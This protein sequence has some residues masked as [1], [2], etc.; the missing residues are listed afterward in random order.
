MT[1]YFDAK[2]SNAV[3]AIRHSY[4]EKNGSIDV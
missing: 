2:G 1:F 3:T 4:F